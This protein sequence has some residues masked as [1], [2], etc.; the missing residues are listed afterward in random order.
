[1]NQGAPPCGMRQHLRIDHG[2]HSQTMLSAL[3][4]RYN[5][6]SWWHEMT[7]RTQHDAHRHRNRNRRDTARHLE[8][9]TRSSEQRRA[10]CATF[11]SRQYP[12][13]NSSTDP[14]HQYA[15]PSM[16]SEQRRLSPPAGQQRHAPFHPHLRF[17]G[18]TS[19]RPSLMALTFFLCPLRL[20]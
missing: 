1:M 2:L 10:S 20:L 18:P 9:D 19:R 13:I 16:G 12:K 15:R 14:P 6:T 11:A 17:R 3:I 5:N 7:Y 4:G 8:P